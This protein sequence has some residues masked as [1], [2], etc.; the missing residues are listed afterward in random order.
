MKRKEPNQTGMLV[1]TGTPGTGK[2]AIA[3]SLA[4][5]IHAN[6]LSLTALVKDERLYTM[7]DPQRQTRVVDMRRTREWLRKSLKWSKALTVLDTHLSDV[8]PRGCVGKV[9]V[10]RCHPRVLEKRLRSRGWKRVKVRENVLAEILDSCYILASKYYGPG[11]VFQVDTS[12]T[13]LRNSVK[14]CKAI[15]GER[16]RVGCMI[17]W[18]SVLDHERILTRYLS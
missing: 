7:V 14:E 9:I 10:L 11:R 6:Y 13:G 1:V 16:C 5:Q 12:R 4:R 3:K 17:D 15:L 8:A 2:T 18:I